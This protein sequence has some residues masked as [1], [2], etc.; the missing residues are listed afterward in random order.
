MCP[1][2]G[3][4]ITREGRL[5]L[6]HVALVVAGEEVQRAARGFQLL[7]VA[8]LHRVEARAGQQRHHV[9]DDIAGRAHFARVAVARAQ[10]ARL[11]V[12]A[13]VDPLRE[14]QRNERQARQVGHQRL[15]VGVV[16]HEDAGGQ[17]RG[18]GLAHRMPL[19]QAQQQVRARRGVLDRAVFAAGDVPLVVVGVDEL[20]GVQPQAAVRWRCASAAVLNG[21]GPMRRTVSMKRSPALRSRR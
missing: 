11:A 6:R 13:A 2:F 17:V 9:D 4:D 1:H 12:G 16:R 8:Q 7:V 14:L 18:P 19:L 21:A 20:H 10:Q 5:R 15:D 3:R